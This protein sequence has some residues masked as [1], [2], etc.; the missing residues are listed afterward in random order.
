MNVLVTGSRH[1]KE[2]GGVILQ[3]IDANVPMSRD[4]LLIHGA[5]AG[6]DFIVAAYAERW[7]WKICAHPAHWEQYGKAAGPLRNQEMLAHHEDIDIVLAFPT[8]DSRGTW[9]MVERAVQA[10]L[11]VRVYPL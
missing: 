2:D 1:V 7:G 5:A 4:H 8:S 9:D 10:R 3:A 6:I 11:P